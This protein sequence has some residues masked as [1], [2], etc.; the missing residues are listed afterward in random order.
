[1]E[2]GIDA[3]VG[4][5]TEKRKIT[6]RR[7]LYLVAGLVLAAGGYVLIRAIRKGILN[8]ISLQAKLL[9]KKPLPPEDFLKTKD[10]PVVGEALEAVDHA[11]KVGGLVMDGENPIGKARAR[12]RVEGEVAKEGIEEERVERLFLFVYGDVHQPGS[13]PEK[14][15]TVRSPF[16]SKLLRFGRD[17]RERAAKDESWALEVRPRR[18]AEGWLSIRLT[19]LANLKLVGD[20]LKGS[21]SA[22]GGAAVAILDV[23]DRCGTGSDIADVAFST[24]ED[25]TFRCEVEYAARGA[26][27]NTEL[28]VQQIKAK[29]N[30]DVDLRNHPFSGEWQEQLY[31]SQTSLQ[32][33]GDTHLVLTIDT[34]L[35]DPFWQEYAVKLEGD[36]RF[37]EY[38]EYMRELRQQQDDL[39]KKA[40]DT[41][42]KIILVG[43]DEGL[44]RKAIDLKKT[45]VTHII[46]GHAHEASRKEFRQ[47]NIEG[48]RIQRIRVGGTYRGVP[49]REDIR[50]PVGYAVEIHPGASEE[51][52][53]HD[54]KVPAYARVI[55]IQYL[56]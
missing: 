22:K 20:F 33:V 32:E 52:V 6:R 47:R 11:R 25:A 37:K 54:L 41:G 31:G 42:K 46:S 45:R 23:G 36:P 44:M 43:H 27:G 13:E 10:L 3:V 35:Y 49:G 55:D 14:E 19:I 29:G 56:M 24:V 26:T 2:K 7:F 17:Q 9:E 12:A 30:H 38:L 40:A 28:T 4:A 48:K 8:P 16:Y 21:E 1:M 50:V 39:I 34:N 53:V 5:E 15:A 51:V 18:L